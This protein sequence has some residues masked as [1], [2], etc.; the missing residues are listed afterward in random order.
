MISSASIVVSAVALL[1]QATLA[2]DLPEGLYEVASDLY[3]SAQDSTLGSY[4]EGEEYEFF[5]EDDEE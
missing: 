5:E 1:S 4:Y 2:S 3:E